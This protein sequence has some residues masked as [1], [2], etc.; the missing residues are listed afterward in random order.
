MINK[1]IAVY[2]GRFQPM[3]RHHYLAFRWLQGMF[4]EDNCYITT[5]D[6]TELPDSPLNFEEK[7]TI[8]DG[9]GVSD[10]VVKVKNPYKCEELTKDFDPETTALVFLVGSKD[11][12]RVPIGPKIDGT[13]GYFEYYREGIQLQ[14]FNKR[15]YILIVPNIQVSVPTYGDM[16]S[17]IVRK[18]LREVEE[19]EYNKVFRDLFGWYDKR[20]A[21]LLKEKLGVSNP[22][23]GIVDLSSSFVGEVGTKHMAHP[24]EIP[25]VNTGKDLLEVFNRTVEGLKSDKA[26]LKIDGINVP[27]KLIGNNS[28]GI[29]RVSNKPLDIAGVG[30]SELVDRFGKGHGMVDIGIK[31][32]NILNKSYESIQGELR[33]LGLTENKNLLL[34]IEFVDGKSNVKSYGKSFIVINGVLEV[35]RVSETRRQTR[36]VSYNPNTLKSLADKINSVAKSFGFGAYSSIDAVMTKTPD[37]EKVLGRE[38]I[39]HQSGNSYHVKTL[40]EWLN[41]IVIPKDQ[42]VKLKDGKTVSALGKELLQDVMFKSIFSVVEN[43]HDY[44]KTIAGY[45][46]NIATMY[47]GQ[48]LLASMTSELG[49]VSNHEGV[50]IRNQ[51]IYNRPYKITG[52][53]IIDGLSSPFNTKNDGSK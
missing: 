2:P 23:S 19:S 20:I 44:G 11:K 42:T 28:F 51:D 7:L 33:E 24:Y 25:T 43:L 3:C 40:G 46:T 37:F 16:S 47:L 39:I 29:D 34:N 9:Y 38:I 50:V 48:E 21:D 36:E 1:I 17:T 45:I 27:V 35:V 8:M 12:D 13:P 22:Y 14:S 52:N 31:L 32:L 18:A 53:F 6:K 41:I 26:A 15:G 5:S 30:I 4:G 10:K 49:D